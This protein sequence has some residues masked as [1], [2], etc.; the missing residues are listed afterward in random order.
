VC[1]PC[2]VAAVAAVASTQPLV[3]TTTSL[4]GV[5]TAEPL[6]LQLGASGGTPPYQ[7]VPDSLP[8]GLLLSSTGLIT[9]AA[10]STGTQQVIVSVVDADNHRTTVALPLLVGAGPVVATSSLPAGTVDEPYSVQLE[11]SSGT[12]PFTWSVAKG[13]V[14]GGLVL[15]SSGLLSG[16]PGTAGTLSIDVQVTDASGASGSA[17]LSTTIAPPPLPSEGYVTIDAAGI[18]TSLDL[19]APSSSTRLGGKSVALAVEPSGAGYWI[20]SS[21]GHVHAAGQARF[22]GSISRRDLQGDIVGIAAPPG[23]RGYWLASSTGHIYG[24]GSARSLG[25]IPKKKLKGKVVAITATRKGRGYFLVTSTGDVYA[26]GAAHLAGSV[27]RRALR[28][29][30]VA[31]AST[32]DGGYLVVSSTGRVYGFGGAR[33]LPSNSGSPS[34]T[35]AAI[36]VVQPPAGSGYWLL[37]T[38]GSIYSYGTAREIAVSPPQPLSTPYAAVPSTAIGAG[39]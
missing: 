25:S 7:W 22:F 27:P 6:G 17:A 9:G 24:F 16:R 26:F 38:T 4:P 23:S 1:G 10:T 18:A 11:E 2:G 33:P 5:E 36:A 32:D 12:A 29:H 20:V 19:V 8:G 31:I 35:I 3:V 14:P 30:I 13:G 15:S 37:T 34:G 28:G 39:R 21:S